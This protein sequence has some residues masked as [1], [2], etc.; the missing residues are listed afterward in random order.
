M[1]DVEFHTT[2][3]AVSLPVFPKKC[4]PIDKPPLKVAVPLTSSIVLL[5]L[6]PVIDKVAP[7]F[8]VRLLQTP[9]VVPDTVGEWVVPDGIV[10]LSMAV[11]IP[12]GFQLP[13]RFQAVL[14]E[15]V[16]VFWAKV[17]PE[18]HRNKAKMVKDFF[19]GIAVYCL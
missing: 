6:V 11:G 13:A 14:V 15:P 1:E 7:E 4:P 9:P 19:I 10:T 5:P 2:F 12:T 18:K 8:T 3:P 16:H 17:S